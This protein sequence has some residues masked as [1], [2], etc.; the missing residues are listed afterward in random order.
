MDLGSILLILSAALLSGVFIS[1][2]FSKSMEEEKLATKADLQKVEHQ[3][4]SLLAEQDRL[5]T[6]LRDLDFDYKMGKIPESDFPDQRMAL[7]NAGAAVLRQLDEID[8][9]HKGVVAET[10]A[11]ESASRIQMNDDELEALIEERRRSRMEKSNGFCPKC[12][13]PTR[14]SDRFCPRCGAQLVEE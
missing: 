7:L 5:I 8:T 14:K 13:K 4:S 9:Q 2:P 10:V 3:R 11:Q 6:T 12:G 1:R